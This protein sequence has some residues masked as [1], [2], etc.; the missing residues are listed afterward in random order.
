MLKRPKID[1]P[2]IF[3]YMALIT[4]LGL[5]TAIVIVVSVLITFYIIRALGLSSYFLMFGILIGLIGGYFN[6]YRVIK[7]FYGK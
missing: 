1:D 5:S 3:K 6:A 7:K 2:E 4:E